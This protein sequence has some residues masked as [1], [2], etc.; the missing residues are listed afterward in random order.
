M[1]L[2]AL[3]A[4]KVLVLQSAAGWVEGL[5]ETVYGLVRPRPAFS[6]SAA[7][8]AASTAA[9]VAARLDAG[10]TTDA[11]ALSARPASW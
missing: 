11:K 2:A 5:A 4:D 3:G 8:S 1:E 6:W 9:Y 7:P 10:L